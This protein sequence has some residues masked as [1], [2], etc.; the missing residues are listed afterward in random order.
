MVRRCGA[1]ECV[2]VVSVLKPRYARIQVKMKTTP[3][4]IP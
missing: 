4:D 3:E 2:V 1:D